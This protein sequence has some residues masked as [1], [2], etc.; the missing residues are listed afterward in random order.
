MTWAHVQVRFTS[1]ARV[2]AFLDAL[3][4]MSPFRQPVFAELRPVLEPPAGK[5]PPARPGPECSYA[6]HRGVQVVFPGDW[7]PFLRTVG[8]AVRLLDALRREAETP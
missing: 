7:G 6:F 8:V 4:P 5:S 3:G 2:G 1:A